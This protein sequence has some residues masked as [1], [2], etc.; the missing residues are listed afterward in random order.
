MADNSLITKEQ[1]Q[2]SVER[3]KD[4]A[5][6]VDGGAEATIPE[7]F[8]EAPYTIEFTNE[9]EDPI[10]A[11]EIEYDGSASGLASSDVQGAIDE[12]K[13]LTEAAPTGTDYE[14]YRLRNVAILSAIP[15]SMNNGDIALV[16]S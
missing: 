9:D 11:N 1:L 4:N 13:A 5:I 6:F 7:V 10:L 12:L 8:G 15:E 2:M 14:E 16:Y 3:V